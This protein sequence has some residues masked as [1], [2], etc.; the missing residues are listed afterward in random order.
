VEAIRATTA[1]DPFFPSIDIGDANV[2]ETF[3]HGGSRINNP[4]KAVL[5]E[6][7]SIFPGQSISCVLSIGSGA[8]GITGFETRRLQSSPKY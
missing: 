5:E 4:V 6:A 3:I 7:V 2:K 1:E 8:Q